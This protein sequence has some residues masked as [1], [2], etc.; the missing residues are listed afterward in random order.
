[1]IGI[2][3]RMGRK[4]TFIVGILIGVLI[5]LPLWL[6]PV[7]EPVNYETSVII[8]MSTYN[9][10][11]LCYIGKNVS[12]IEGDKAI[13]ICLD[14]VAAYRRIG[15]ILEGPENT[16]FYA[17]CFCNYAQT[18]FYA[19]ENP[20]MGKLYMVENAEA[21]RIIIFLNAIDLVLELKLKVW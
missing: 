17:L 10:M 4:S 18:I 16:T 6:T 5:M 19:M 7:Y 12:A 3:K 8:D 13:S 9:D 1:M 2:W 14:T 15:I 21:R 11:Y 20:E